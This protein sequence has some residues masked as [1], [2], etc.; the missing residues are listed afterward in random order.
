MAAVSAFGEGARS[1]QGNAWPAPYWAWR[2]ASIIYAD[3]IDAVGLR[4]RHEIGQAQ[5]AFGTGADVAAGEVIALCV[6]PR[7]LRWGS[8][9]HV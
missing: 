6:A 5:S 7:N 2:I 9:L 4:Q 3:R 1:S 8:R